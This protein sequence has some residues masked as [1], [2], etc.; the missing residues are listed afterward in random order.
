MNVE[1]YLSKFYSLD[2]IEKYIINLGKATK[3]PILSIPKAKVLSL[4]VKLK[5][6][7]NSF[8][9]GLGIG[10]STYSI[11]KSLDKGKL[12]SID[13]NFHR[14]EIFY[15]KIYRKFNEAIKRKLTVYPVDA[16]YC[17]DIFC[18]L[19]KKFDF[20]FIDSQKRDYFYFYDY[21]LKLTK[22][23]S[24]I[25]IDNITYNFQTF[26]KIDGRSKKYLEGVK[27]VEK[28]IQKVS[29]S[30]YFKV[31]FLPIGDGMCSLIRL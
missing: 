3:T 25:V 31:G 29:Y 9:I 24:L 21:L 6:P 14:I 19:K 7:E 8:E 20:I 2:N 5:N 26:K 13:K 22:K 18:N 30:N 1:E 11:L 16:F 17:M 27:L 10:F 23:G 12:I 4:L 15:E 28:F